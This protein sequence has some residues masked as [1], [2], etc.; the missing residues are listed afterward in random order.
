MKAEREVNALYAALLMEDR[1]GE[2]F[3]ATVSSITDFGF[4][5][6]LDAEH[7]EGLVRAEDLGTG[8]RLV[9]GALVWPDGRRVQVGQRLTARLAGVSVPRRQITFEVVAFEGQK[10]VRPRGAPGKAPKGAPSQPSRQAKPAPHG[11]GRRQEKPGRGQSRRP[12]AGKP[13]RKR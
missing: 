6:E 7:V 4:F 2:E 9:V 1:V 12:H 13:R 8:H 5:V 10:P 11:R 3:A